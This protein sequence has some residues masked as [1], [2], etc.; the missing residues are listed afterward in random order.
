VYPLHHDHNAGDLL[1]IRSRHQFT[2]D[3]ASA[4]T[5]PT[6]QVVFPKMRLARCRAV[7]F[8]TGKSDVPGI[9]NAD[10]ILVAAL[11]VGLGK[12]IERHDRNEGWLGSLAG[13]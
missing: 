1:V 7:P 11:F 3:T 12:R 9:A 5:D 2:S 6:Y 13:S 10:Q 8:M 4:D